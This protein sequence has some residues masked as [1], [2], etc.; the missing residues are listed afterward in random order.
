MNS[1][2]RERKD[3]HIENYLRTRSDQ[4]THLEDV[5]IEHNAIS[6]VSLEEIDTSIEF[7]DRKIAMPL[8]VD[9]MTGGGT[10]SASINEDLSSICE[11][12]NIPMAVGS[13]SI[14]LT[15]ESSRESFELVKAK[16]DLFRIG[17]LGF[18]LLYTS[19]SP[20]DRG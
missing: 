18:C 19:P 20:R 16:K 10:S 1:Q 17:N 4:R 3:Q 2:R 6:D 5:Y 8:M 15:D 13:E 9:A 7:M 11:S 14:A 12:L